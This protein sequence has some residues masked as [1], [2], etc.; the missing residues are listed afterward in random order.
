VVELEAV[1]WEGQGFECR[2]LVIQAKQINAKIGCEVLA[3]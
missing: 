2:C 3:V 1:N